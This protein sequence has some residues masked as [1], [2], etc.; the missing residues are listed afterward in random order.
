MFDDSNP[1]RPNILFIMNDQH[2]FDYLGCMGADF[3]NT[4]NID[5][6]ARNGVVF[7]NCF[8]NSPVCA[9]ARIGLA[10]GM[11]PSRLGSLDNHSYLPLSQRTYYQRLRDAGYYVGCVGKLD[12]AKPDPYNGI[13]GDRPIN[14][15]WGFTHPVECEGKMH[16]GRGRPGAPLGPYNAWLEE[17][18]LLQ[19]F[20][21]D[22]M[23]RQGNWAG[24]CRDSVLPTEA[25]EDCYIG[26]RAAEWIDD[27]PTDFPWHLFVSFVGPHDPFDPPTEYA[28]KYRNADVPEPILDEMEGKPEWIRSRDK[29]FDQGTVRRTRQQYCAE[30]E[31][32][33]DQV[34]KILDSLERKGQLDNTVII[35]SSD[36]GEMLGDHGL[37]TKSVMYEA[38]M[39]VPLAVSA[40]GM[41]GGRQSN[42]IV[43]LIDI[44]PTICELAGLEPQN[45]IDARS[46]GP[47]VRGEQD[48]HRDDAVSA[49]RNCRCLRTERYKLIDNY[50]QGLELYDLQEDPQELHNISGDRQ[51]LTRD[52]CRRMVGRFVEGRW[53]R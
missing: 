23:V 45:D 14:Y 28:D 27:I 36:H 16:A 1:Q 24:D 42:A 48:A 22:Y 4:P 41:K 20:H 32:L 10:A 51:D 17:K 12:L 30:I 31:C 52:L 34:G 33:D 39:H 26:T 3:V 35:F 18:G 43:E 19:E 8:S 15:A 21:E 37:Y 25:W 38:S 5:R 6:I 2:R 40:P 44:N 13:R 49:L 50:Q 29:E 11:Q 46:F 9:P 7:R 47:V 53:M